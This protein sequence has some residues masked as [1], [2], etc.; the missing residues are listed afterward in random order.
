VIDLGLT[1]LLF[2]IVVVLLIAKIWLYFQSGIT[3]ML[4]VIKHVLKNSK[5]TTQLYLIFANQVE[6]LNLIGISF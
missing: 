4:Q 2:I 6:F 5:D 1:N 3:P